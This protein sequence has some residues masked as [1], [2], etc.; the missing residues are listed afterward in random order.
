MA[1][2]LRIPVK[3]TAAGRRPAYNI[4]HMFSP[5]STLAD[6]QTAV[7][8]LRDFYTSIA[9][10]FNSTTAI[11][12]G[13]NVVR[14]TDVPP[15]I[16]PVTIRNLVGT[17]GTTQAP[18][19][20][21]NVISLRTPL[22]G[23]SFRGRIYLGPISDSAM[24]GAIIGG[25]LNT[26]MQTAAATLVASNLVTVWSEKLQNHTIVTSALTNTAVETQRR[27]ARN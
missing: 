22:A 23:R 16:L 21:A 11:E 5:A 20:L 27:R 6:A 1:G 2:I 4:W 9:A 17:G 19:Q 12:I 18:Y 13:A 7:D 25:A 8:L 14:I 3:V 24:T 26:T 10:L 15:V